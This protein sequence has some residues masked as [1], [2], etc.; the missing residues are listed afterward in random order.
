M[1]LNP[2]FLTTV[3]P[4]RPT[5][6]GMGNTGWV[7]LDPVPVALWI[8]SRGSGTHSVTLGGAKGPSWTEFAQ[9]FVPKDCGLQSGDRIPYQGLVYVISGTPSGDQVHPFT[10]NDFGFMSFTV[11]GHQ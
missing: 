9:I 3:V 11:E 6:D 5:D 8:G 10:G 4:Q 1:L 7:D 2:K